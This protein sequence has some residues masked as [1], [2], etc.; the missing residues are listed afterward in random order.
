M[1]ARAKGL[2]VAW[3]RR[4]LLLS[5]GTRPTVDLSGNTALSKESGLASKMAYATRRMLPLHA[6]DE[7]L[8]FGA[9][10]LEADLSHAL[11]HSWTGHVHVGGHSEVAQSIE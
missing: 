4:A 6:S 8:G 10:R 7:R 2:L 11:R 3:D 1:Q 5:L 9:A